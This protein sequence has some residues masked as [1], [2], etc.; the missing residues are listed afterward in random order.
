M[1]RCVKSSRSLGAFVK[2]L[3]E[4]TIPWRWFSSS[5]FLKESASIRAY[6]SPRPGL[7]RMNSTLQ[8]DPGMRVRSSSRDAVS[9]FGGAITVAI[10]TLPYIAA[11]LA[12]RAQYSSGQTPPSAASDARLVRSRV[13]GVL[14]LALAHLRRIE[15]A[16]GVEARLRLGEGRDEDVHVEALEERRSPHR[17]GSRAP[18]ERIALVERA[19]RLA[20]LPVEDRQRVLLAARVR[21][22]AHPQR[23]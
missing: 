16:G 3:Y 13:R 5:I 9:V 17:L 15:E 6:S 10:R 8:T 18:A 4:R 1:N 19:R 20:D 12:M 23:H 7:T 22:A 14:L 2:I 11:P 21:E